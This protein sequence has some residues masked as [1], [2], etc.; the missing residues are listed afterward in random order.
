M[1]A[2]INIGILLYAIMVPLSYVAGHVPSKK[3]KKDVRDFCLEQYKTMVLENNNKT[4]RKK[5]NEQKMSVIALVPKKPRKMK[6]CDEVITFN[7]DIDH[8][9]QKDEERKKYEQEDLMQCM[10]IYNNKR[11]NKVEYNNDLIIITPDDSSLLKNKQG[12]LTLPTIDESIINS[13]IGVISKTK[14]L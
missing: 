7:V 3:F 13:G 5:K 8:F 12:G 4:N 9:R 6:S 11:R 10:R 14:K 2:S 1:L